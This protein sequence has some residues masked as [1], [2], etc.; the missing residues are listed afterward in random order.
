MQTYTHI[1]VHIHTYTHRVTY[2]G[3][4]LVAVFLVVVKLNTV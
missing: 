1:Y 4:Q 3:A 2:F